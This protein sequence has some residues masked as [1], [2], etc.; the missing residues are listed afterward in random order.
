MRTTPYTYGLRNCAE[1][2]TP[3]GSRPWGRVPRA[4]RPRGK[5]A[6]VGGRP[7]WAI[8]Q[9]AQIVGK[10]AWTIPQS[11]QVAEKLIAKRRTRPHERARSSFAM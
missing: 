8:P 4:A 6:W 7:A 11:A 1:V 3:A 2:T 9:P 10:L 5:S